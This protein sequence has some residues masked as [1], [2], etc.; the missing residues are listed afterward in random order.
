MKLIWKK[1]IQ[2]FRPKEIIKSKSGQWTHRDEISENILEDWIFQYD[3]AN[4]KLLGQFNSKNLKG[5]GIE[6]LKLAIVAAGGIL[7]YL[8]ITE[9]KQIGHIKSISRI[10]E[11]N[12]VWLD[13]F[14]IRNLD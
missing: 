8:E 13:Q 4:E 9:H 1:L 12:Y 7:H 6:Q 11:E 10:E 3:F 14:T 2:G 5:F